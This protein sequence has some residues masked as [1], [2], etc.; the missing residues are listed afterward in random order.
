MALGAWKCASLV[1]GVQVLQGTCILFSGMIPHSP[2]PEEHPLWQMALRLGA[3]CTSDMLPEVTHVVAKHS[4]TEKVS[5]QVCVS[6]AQQ[7]EHADSRMRARTGVLGSAE[8]EA[9]G[10]QGMVRSFAI[11]L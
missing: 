5:E 10:Q 6:V 3:R 4:S 2:H 8:Q 7:H 11:C 1:A 9:P